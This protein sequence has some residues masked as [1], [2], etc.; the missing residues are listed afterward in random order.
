MIEYELAAIGAAIIAVL[1]I[2]YQV[3]TQK[4]I[5]AIDTRLGKMKRELDILQVQ[6]SRR[7]IMAFRRNSKVGAP[8]TE[9]Y[10]G[11]RVEVDGRD[12]VLLTGTDG[13]TPR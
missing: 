8:G 11:D 1:C 3:K 12:V 6:A 9:L 5:D 4:Q 10:D 13:Q 7:A 2:W